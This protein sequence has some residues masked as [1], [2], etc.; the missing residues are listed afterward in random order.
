LNAVAD[1][2]KIKYFKITIMKKMFITGLVAAGV[3]FAAC[4]KN[5]A[6]PSYTPP[7][8]KNFSV[9]SLKHTQDTVAVGDTI[10]LN[11]AGTM[12]DTTQNIYPYIS[13]ASTGNT[14]TYGTSTASLTTSKTP[15]KLTKVIGASTNGV[16]AWT[17]TIT[18]I[19]ATNVPS[20]TTLTITGVFNYQLS[21]STE[22]GGNA[23]ATDA[24]Q[25]TK[26]ILVL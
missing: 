9:T 1:V 23:T 19:G 11:V 13:V 14:F 25:A 6:L 20:G 7:V 10:Y 12:A 22:G 17:S 21:F 18:L 4:V 8:A 2:E 15:V 5:T 16:Y 24:G 26:T 3:L